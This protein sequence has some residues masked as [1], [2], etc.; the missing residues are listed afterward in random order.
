MPGE[1]EAPPQMQEK[2]IGPG[3]G[4]IPGYISPMEHCANCEYF[5]GDSMCLKYDAPADMDGGCP[6]FEASSGGGEEGG[7]LEETGE[8]GEEL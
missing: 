3:E 8:P 5:D 2:P 6:A 1:S 4:Q 7:E